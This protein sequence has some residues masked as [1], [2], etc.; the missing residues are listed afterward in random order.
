MQWMHGWLDHG[1]VDAGGFCFGVVFSG[2][3]ALLIL[4][5]TREQT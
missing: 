5:Q 4:E 3:G 2:E 1:I